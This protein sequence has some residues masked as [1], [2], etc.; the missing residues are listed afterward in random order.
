MTIFFQF[1][2]DC[3]HTFRKARMLAENKQTNKQNNN[4]NNNSDNTISFFFRM[5]ALPKKKNTN[6]QHLIH[7]V[8]TA[9]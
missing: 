5:H 1:V 7:M 9:F 3:L 6:L 8:T 2:S 4:N